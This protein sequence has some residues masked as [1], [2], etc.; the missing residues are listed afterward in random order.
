MAVLNK[1]VKDNFTSPIKGETPFPV[2][3]IEYNKA[4]DQVNTNTTNISTN[5]A[6]ISASKAGAVLTKGTSLTPSD[7]HTINA[8][9]GTCI[10]THGATAGLATRTVTITNSF[11]TASSVVMASIADYGGNGS[12]IVKEV[13][14]AAGSIVIEI[15]NA[16]AT[17]AL[18]ANF[19]LS[20]A[21]LA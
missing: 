6:N 13:S 15:Y 18:S 1:V 11:A 21:I 5:T 10:V 16:H 4:V 9:A 12:P 20:F 19:E 2:Y 17:E 7:A 8:P 14:P 3:S